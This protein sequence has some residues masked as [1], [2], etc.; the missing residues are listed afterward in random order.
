MAGGTTG[1]AAGASAGAGG[2]AAGG[3]APV[4]GAGG[5][6]ATGPKFSEIHTLLMGKCAMCHMGSLGGLMIGA[7]KN[8]TYMSLTS[9]SS[10][11]GMC[12][13]MK[14][15][16]PNMPDSSVLVQA[17]KAMGCRSGMPMPPPPGTMLSADDA[18]KVSDWIAAGAKND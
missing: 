3:G 7:D 1:G 11:M 10:T 17:I 2:G 16:V 14:R 13:G 5:G 12:M 9:S 18:K 4:G 8:A 6:A 15:V